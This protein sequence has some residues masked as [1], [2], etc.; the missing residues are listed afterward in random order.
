M[1][2][3]TNNNKLSGSVSVPGSKSHT[4]RAL[5]LAALGE[6]VSHIHN[7][8]PS[9]DC[10]SAA[11]AIKAFGADCDIGCPVDENGHPQGT[12]AT[13]WVVTGAGKNAHAPDVTVDVGNSGST[14]Y[15]FTPVA[16]TFNGSSTFTGDESICKRPVSH[17]LDAL[18]QLGATAATERAG[19]DAPPFTVTGPIAP[20]NIVTDG[21]LSQY[22]S[23]LMMASTRVNGT[24]T[25]T[26][27]DPKETPYLTMTKQWLESVGFPVTM[28]D[29]FTSITV[30]GPHTIKAFDRTVP[31]DWEGVAF[32]LMAA[33][34]SHSD[35][36][37]TGVDCTGSQGDEAVVDV[38]RQLGADIELK[39]DAADAQTGTLY[40]NGSKTPK[41]AV[42]DPSGVLRVN[43]SGF[44][45]AVCALAVL[46]AFTDGTVVLD[47]TGV[48]RKK[49]TDR[50]KVMQDELRKLGAD[51][52][53]GL[54]LSESDPLYG[55][56]LVIHGSSDISRLH[57][58]TVESYL[59]HR[60]AMSF[61]CMGLGLPAGE[62]IT[63]KDAECCSVS[64]PGFFQVM[65][66]IG[67]GFRFA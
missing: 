20:G 22:I 34:L 37:I 40:V 67:A 32:P 23:G 28:A 59:D 33:L 13:T 57:G 38:L 54:T 21:R 49:E 47:D 61:A 25:M 39:K 1:N 18:V 3:S 36:A 55:D 56:C 45:D 26:L 14:L 66:S 10:L 6:G 35:I 46:A 27:T 52:T 58:A 19:V 62:T 7:P 65:N 41:L 15:F 48:C 64:F 12:P 4:I 16:A 5:L 60:V 2:V 43:I 42:K 53:D 31:A 44:P 51:V 63:V 50:I 11:H 9:A 24:I 8:L 29:D 17:L 30:T